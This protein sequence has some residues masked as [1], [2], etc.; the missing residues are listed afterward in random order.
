[1][2][3]FLDTLYVFSLLRE[4]KTICKKKKKRLSKFSE[5]SCNTEIENQFKLLNISTNKFYHITLAKIFS[6]QTKMSA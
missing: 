4:I 6:N 5:V 3:M 1:M 2:L